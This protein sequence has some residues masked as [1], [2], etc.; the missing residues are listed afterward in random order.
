MALAILAT[1]AT[2][3]PA[4]AD[5]SVSTD[6]SNDISI[7]GMVR[8]RVLG[9]GKINKPIMKP[10]VYGTVSAVNGNII[11]VTK[12]QSSKMNTTVAPVTVTYTVDATNAT[13]VKNNVAGTIASIV[14]GD[15]IVAQGTLTGTNLVATN[16]RDGI[17]MGKE[18]GGF[19][20]IENKN[21]QKIPVFSGNGQP[22]VAGTVTAVNGTTLTVTN[23]SNVTYTI[24]ATNAKIL[25][26]PNTILVSNVAVGDNI[27][28]QGTVNG[29]AVV[30][31]TVIDQAKV[32][33]T[34]AEHQGFFA[35]IGLFFAHLFGY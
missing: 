33:G 14:V 28:V 12:T 34:K 8:G 10:A 25:Q 19:S 6:Q 31:A 9:I 13:I 30:A 21:N 23:K 4:F 29:N 20:K 3:V 15:T 11:T 24:D 17:M 32:A 2:A 35:G 5:N 27:V 7:G 18:R 22:I 16:I 26:G 1:L